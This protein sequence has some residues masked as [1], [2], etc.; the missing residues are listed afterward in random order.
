MIN[1]LG[2][3][4]LRMPPVILCPACDLAH[5]RTAALGSGGTRCARC[6]AQLQ[7]PQGATVDTALAL[8]VCAMVLLW[9]GNAYP[10]VAMHINGSSRETTLI[11]AAIGL[12]DQGYETLA[13]LVILT[14]VVA[15]L[16]QIVTLLYVLVPVWRNRAAYGQNALI[17]LVTRV[18]VWSFM[19]VFM[20]GA[21]VALVRLSK[22]AHVVPGVALWSCALLMLCLSAL[23][24]IAS[25]GQLWRWAAP[26]YE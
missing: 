1:H 9:L 20:L 2:Y 15:P 6:H 18:R 13:A 24:S 4:D 23:A 12:H 19:E 17:R 25:P 22:F 3:D 21:V 26:S 7:R 10:L 14:T 5:R 8:A 16:V 11:G